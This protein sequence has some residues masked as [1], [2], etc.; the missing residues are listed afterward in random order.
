MQCCPRGS[1]QHCMKKI[2]CNFALILLVRQVKTL[3]HVVQEAP[4]K[5]AS[6]KILCNVLLILSGQHCTVKNPMQYCPRGSRQHCIKNILCN[7]ALILLGQHCIGWNPMKCCPKGSRQHCIRKNSLQC[8]LNTLG[9]KL[10]SWKPYAMLPDSLQT[11]LHKKNFP[12]NFPMLSQR[13]QATLH[14]KRIRQ[15][16]QCRLNNIWSLCLYM[17][18]SGH[19]HKKNIKLSFLYYENWLKLRLKQQHGILPSNRSNF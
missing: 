14:R 4:D 3:S 5:F 8:T 11:T 12:F 18:I 2:L 16:W 7:F 17:Y 1:R 13:L 10:H 9:T 19:S 6:E 15:C